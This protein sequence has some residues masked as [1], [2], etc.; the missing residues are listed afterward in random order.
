[1]D[2]RL[3]NIG[4]IQVTNGDI[5]RLN[6]PYNCKLTS[7]LFLND[8]II[9]SFNY[10]TDKFV[11]TNLSLSC[12]FYQRLIHHG[13]E[14][15]FLNLKRTNK[16]KYGNDNFNIFKN[17]RTIVIP[18]NNLIGQHWSVVCLDTVSKQMFFMDS[19][20]QRGDEV[21]NRIQQFISYSSANIYEKISLAS[22]PRQKNS[23][24]CGIFICLYS[25]QFAINKPPRII[26]FQTVDMPLYRFLIRSEILDFP[27]HHITSDIL[28][29]I[30]KT[31]VKKRTEPQLQSD[32]Q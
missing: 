17:F 26:Q 21:M 32:T 10:I 15:T 3:T 27:Q 22:V 11:P 16:K 28:F 1:M 8:V 13:V 29:K 14:A 12:F 9:D 7:S 2:K 6:S 18:I 30:L 23:Y 4:N 5:V 31:A 25:R 19:F 20:G 24:D